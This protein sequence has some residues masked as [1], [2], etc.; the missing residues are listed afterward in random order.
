MHEP[1]LDDLPEAIPLRRVTPAWRLVAIMALSGAGALGLLALVLGIWVGHLHDELD[2]YQSGLYTV[3]PAWNVKTP[4]VVEEGPVVDDGPN[5]VNLPYPVTEDL[6]EVARPAPGD[7][8]DRPRDRFLKT[9]QELWKSPRGQHVGQVVV[10]PDGSRLTYFGGSSLVA[11]AVENPNRIEVFADENG[12]RQPQRHHREQQLAGQPTWSADSRYVY[13]ATAGGVL[14]RYDVENNQLEKLPFLGQS[15]APVPGDPDRIVFTR[16]LPTVKT[17]AGPQREPA[18]RGELAIGNLTTKEVRVL[19]GPRPGGWTALAVSPDA[20][21]VAGITARAPKDNQ[22]QRGLAVVAM[23]SRKVQE[24]GLSRPAHALEAPLAWDPQSKV[25]LYARSQDPAPPDCWA[26]DEDDYLGTTDLFQIDIATGKE[27]R[28]SRGGG[29]ASP[30]VT[31]AGTLCF[32]VSPPHMPR[33]GRV[34]ARVFL[35][36][37]PLTTAQQFAAQRPEVPARDA[38]AWNALFA[39]VCKETSIGSDVDGAALTPAVLTSIKEAFQKAYRARFAQEPPADTRALT[40]LT[41]ELQALPL[42]RDDLLRCRLVLGVLQG[43]EL[44]DKHGARWQLVQGP[45]FGRPLDDPRSA[46]VFGLALNPFQRTDDEITPGWFSIEA[47]LRQADGRP[48]L[49]T[50]DAPTARAVLA[51]NADPDLA[52]G[53]KMLAD[54]Q[55]ADGERLLV[56]MLAKDEHKNNIRLSLEVC[57]LLYEH[58][59]LAALRQLVEA[60]CQQPPYDARQ[61]NYLGLAQLDDDPR[62]ALNAF[63]KALRCDL[64]HGPAYLNLALAYDKLGEKAHARAVLKRYLDL[65]PHGPYAADALRRLTVLETQE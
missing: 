40:R 13:F 26:D 39:E 36:Q 38:A 55:K 14:Q 59:R 50:N 56:S 19:A 16:Y 25:L 12:D 42:N 61:F 29:F 31:S 23:E 47:A 54:G 60:R 10:S 64:R 32:L 63:K 28:L 20:K 24:V 7:R 34:I 49:L 43:A 65:A 35:R 62:Q 2:N 44:R 45:L 58:Q 1:R 30:S 37:L 41:Q 21:L 9:T 17:E 57:G 6:K 3:P 52:N 22:A 4:P 15:P 51:K 11:G 46:E 33:D 48:L 5:A 53:R 27:M 8:P 18:D